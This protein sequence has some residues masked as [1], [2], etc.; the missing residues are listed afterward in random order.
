MR[1][2]FAP[3][4]VPNPTA[5]QIAA[6]TYRANDATVGDV[7]VGGASTSRVGAIHNLVARAFEDSDGI[8]IHWV[9]AC[10]Q[11]MG[12]LRAFGW[13]AKDQSRPVTCQRCQASVDVNAPTTTMSKP[14]QIKLLR[15]ALDMAK[16]GLF[17]QTSEYKGEGCDT[18]HET[19]NC[20]ACGAYKRLL[21][22]EKLTRDA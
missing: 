22:V 9:P 12:H 6:A 18:C 4:P 5:N 3:R 20:K 15:G 14:D 1:S 2:I 7:C 11:T 17:C 19:C 16:N 21:Y 8:S 10:C 13:K